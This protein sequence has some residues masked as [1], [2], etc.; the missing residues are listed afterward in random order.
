MNI[1]TPNYELTRIF[2]LFFIQLLIQL[3]EECNESASQKMT[4]GKEWEFL[5]INVVRFT[6]P[7]IM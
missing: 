1:K 3:L 7:D 6:T 4:A 2:N 5:C